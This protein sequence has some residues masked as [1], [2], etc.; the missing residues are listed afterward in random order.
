M[1][2]DEFIDYE[3]L[4]KANIK[5]CWFKVGNLAENKNGKYY[6]YEIVKK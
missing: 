6:K 1:S 4:Q 2:I 3:E 5:H